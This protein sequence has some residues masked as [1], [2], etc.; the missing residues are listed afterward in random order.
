MTIKSVSREESGF[1][2]LEGV[3][4]R[5]AR[6]KARLVAD[7]DPGIVTVADIGLLAAVNP[8]R[9]GAL[10]LLICPSLPSAIQIKLGICPAKLSPQ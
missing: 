10:Q 5:A 6:I 3:D 1:L 9:K 8:L 7:F 2:I 4:A